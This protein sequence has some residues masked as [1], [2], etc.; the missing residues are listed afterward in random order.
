MY[1]RARKLLPELSADPFLEHA[2][3]RSRKR[4]LL[5]GGW[6]RFESDS[7]TLMRVVESAYAGL[8]GHRLSA[9][10]PRFEVKLL[11]MRPR[12]RAGPSD[13]REPASLRM[14]SGGALLGAATESSDAVLIS[15]AERRAL[16]A[17]SPEMLRSPYHTRYEMLEFAVFT[18]AARAQGLVPLHAACV[19]RGGQG[20]LIMGPSGAGKSTLGL[21]CL[22]D[23]LDFLAEDSVFVEPHSMRATGVANFLHLRAD[24]LRWAGASPQASAF[25]RAPV[26][27]RRSGVEK[28]EIDLR[29]SG[30]SLAQSPVRIGAVLFLSAA[31]AADGALLRPLPRAE[32]ARRLAAEQAY[33][34]RQSPWRPFMSGMRRIKTFE[35]R[36]GTHPRA[37]VRA[38]KALLGECACA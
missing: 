2:A 36:R 4:M 20:V 16:I 37:G 11:E 29:D 31:A 22:L 21:Q 13:R 3:A 7:P 17:V 8:P 32:A 26:I 27:R 9:S 34:V 24:A 14:L 5:L 28:Y 6:F 30:F 12:R 19:G 15:P 1:Q 18:L 25:R 35:M 23:G 10:P 38:L 33:A